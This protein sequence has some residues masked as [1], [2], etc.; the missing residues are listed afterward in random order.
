VIALPI[1]LASNMKRVED[2]SEETGY[3]PFE[4]ERLERP[5]MYR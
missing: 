1:W 3:A 4:L 5:A 2:A